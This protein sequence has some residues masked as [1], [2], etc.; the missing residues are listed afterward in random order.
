M[1][2]LIVLSL[3]ATPMFA[4]QVKVS[5]KETQIDA[6]GIGMVRIIH[7]ELGEPIAAPDRLTI[8]IKCKASGETKE[9]AVYRLC[10]FDESSYD[11]QSKILNVKMT[12]GRVVHHSGEVICDKVD[13]KAID[14]TSTCSGNP[15]QKNSKR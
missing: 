11:E 5:D 10:K 7:D 8:S 13:Y 9:L 6:T 1:K 4:E 2:N 12:S 15:K 14:L 3:F